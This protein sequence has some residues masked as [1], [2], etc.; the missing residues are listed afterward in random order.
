MDISAGGYALS[1]TSHFT[2][3]F[4]P[5]FQVS[6]TEWL[7]LYETY[8]YWY[9]AVYVVNQR[10]KDGSY[11]RMFE[12]GCLRDK[13]GCIGVTLWEYAINDVSVAL[14]S[15]KHTFSIANVKVKEFMAILSLT[16]TSDKCN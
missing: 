11:R 5:F 8:D 1:L 16:T 9:V 14:E 12:G 10:C 13:S 3:Y 6:H 15:G 2:W 4:H 7:T